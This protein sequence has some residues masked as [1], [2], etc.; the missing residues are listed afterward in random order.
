MHNYEKLIERLKKSEGQQ[1]GTRPGWRDIATKLRPTKR[2]CGLAVL[3]VG[4]TIS[5]FSTKNLMEKGVELSQQVEFSRIQLYDS[6]VYGGNECPVYKRDDNTLIYSFGGAAF[7][8]GVAGVGYLLTR[9]D[10]AIRSA[11]TS[12]RKRH[13]I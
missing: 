9:S 1:S 7:G 8:L 5:T 13:A 6:I 4:L 11:L 10:S 2:I 3:L 12:R